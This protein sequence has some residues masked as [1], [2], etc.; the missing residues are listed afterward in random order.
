M[1]NLQEQS[2]IRKVL[3]NEIAQVISIVVIV[4]SFITLVIFPIKAIQYDI[5]N[6]K[7]NHLHTIELDMAELKSLQS[8]ETKENNDA[9]IA[10]IRELEKTATILD[11]HLKT[12]GK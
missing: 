9:H 4:Y 1:E 3:K 2:A 11:Q 8:N 12:S 10:I 5:D 7:N 6:I